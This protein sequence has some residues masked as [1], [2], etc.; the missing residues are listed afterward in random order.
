MRKRS[1][2][3]GRGA[4]PMFPV[5]DFA[6]A[7]VEPALKYLR[8]REVTVRFER[9]LQAL[10]FAGDGVAALD[11]E[12]DRI[13]LSP[14]RRRDPRRPAD[15]RERAGAGA[16]RAQRIHG[17]AD[18]PL[19]GPAARRRAA[20][21]R[22]RSM[23]RSI[24]CFAI[25]IESARACATPA[26]WLDAPREKLAAD[27]WRAA[28]GLTGLSDAVARLARHPAKARAPLPRRRRKTR[29]GRPARRPG[30]TSSSPAP[31]CRTDCRRRWRA[32][33]ARAKSR[34]ETCLAL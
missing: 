8:R 12:Q 28:A 20:R 22:R 27:F 1:R 24:G 16:N 33:C 6:R 25:P 3:G 31:M 19:R 5:G 34:R 18:R 13:D 23:A 10:D 29:C 17:D 2:R 21:A 9:N 14:E 7:F 26:R 32:R 11:F 4:R 30:A 15:H